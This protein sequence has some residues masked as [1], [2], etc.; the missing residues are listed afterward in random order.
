M[1][2]LPDTFSQ[3]GVPLWTGSCR[4]L[5]HVRVD[6]DRASCLGSGFIQLDVRLLRDRALTRDQSESSEVGCARIAVSGSEIAQSP[7][8]TKQLD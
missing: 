3:L 4:G 5:G 7:K 8:K 2:W 1:K 6:R